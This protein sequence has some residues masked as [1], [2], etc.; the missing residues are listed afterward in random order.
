MVSLSIRLN[1]KLDVPHPSEKIMQTE[2][3]VRTSG[4]EFDL[5]V[6]LVRSNHRITANAAVRAF[7][8]AWTGER[9]KLYSC[10]YEMSKW[11]AYQ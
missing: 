8:L 3:D 1:S 4:V 7:K 5:T 2:F 11:Q 10:R 6:T 9:L